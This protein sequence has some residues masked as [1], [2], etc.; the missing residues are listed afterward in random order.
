MAGKKN[1]RSSKTAHVLNLL[2]HPDEISQSPASSPASQ[3]NSFPEEVESA[4]PPPSAP[5]PSYTPMDP[6]QPASSRHLSPP[7][8]EVARTNNEA[9]E[10]SIHSALEQ[11]LEEEERTLEQDSTLTTEVQESIAP[12][13]NLC[14]E[15]FFSASETAST[16]PN[17]EKDHRFEDLTADSDNNPTLDEPS[18]CVEGEIPV[19]LDA[20]TLG[21]PSNLDSVEHDQDFPPDHARFLNVM[22]LLVEE[23]LEHYVN[24]FHL[25]SCPRCLADTKAL[26]LS[27]L[28]SKYVVL[29]AAAYS[30]MINFY[31]AKYDA[32]VTSQ[33][34]YACKQVMESPRHG[35]DPI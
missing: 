15:D 20:Q 7:I 19:P 4:S 9:L 17:Q 27:R 12:E 25:C 8:L 22:Q 1:T 16:E 32:E 35:N 3:V 30:P 14:Q 33:I 24:L 6:P 28:P 13:N 29:G 34:I 11:A 10:A 5:E 23:K 18:P 26:A 31:R 2:S 21:S